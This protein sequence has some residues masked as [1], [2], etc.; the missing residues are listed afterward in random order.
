M[1]NK[2]RYGEMVQK[3]RGPLVKGKAEQF[4]KT[5]ETNRPPSHPE[6]AKLPPK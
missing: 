5:L 6:E 3:Q 2:H 1:S 4:K